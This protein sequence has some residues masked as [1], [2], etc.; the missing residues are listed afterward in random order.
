MNWE[1]LKKYT[2]ANGFVTLNDQAVDGPGAGNLLLHTALAYVAAYKHEFVIPKMFSEIVKLCEVRPGL[3]TRSPYKEKDRQEHDD[4]IGVAAAAYFYAPFIALDIVK[5][6]ESH[7]WCY[8]SQNPEQFDLTLVHDRF[9]GQVSFYKMC[10]HQKLSMWEALPLAIRSMIMSFSSKGD[11]AIHSY[12]FFSV[13]I[14]AMPLLFLPLWWF[15]GVKK[16]IG[17][18]FEPYLG[19]GHPLNEITK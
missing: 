16:G 17:K 10:A 11:S 9:A 6:G 19:F 2:D 4:Y 12:L 1:S 7:N 5:H 18:K 3:L 13:G 14:E 15:S 8:N